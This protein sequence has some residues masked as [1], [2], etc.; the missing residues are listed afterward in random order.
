MP[1]KL[2]LSLQ[3]RLLHN[4]VVVQS[5]RCGVLRDGILS[6]IYAS[7]TSVAY[8]FFTLVRRNLEVLGEKAS[9]E[10]LWTLTYG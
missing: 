2:V 1:L 5:E 8:F 7:N 4:F 3:F 9:G 6:L 10:S